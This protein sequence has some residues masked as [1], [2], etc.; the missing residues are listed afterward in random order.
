MCCSAYFAENNSLVNLASKLLDKNNLMNMLSKLF[1]N[2]SCGVLK[3][4]GPFMTP[5][6]GF[7]SSFESTLRFLIHGIFNI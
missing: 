1:Y 5:P 4:L 6:N 2:P 7:L 3:S